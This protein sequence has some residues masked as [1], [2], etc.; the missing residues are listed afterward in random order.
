MAFAL[1][2][3]KSTT[4]G[5]SKTEK[6]ATV[7]L[8]KNQI[9]NKMKNSI[10]KSIL[11]GVFSLFMVVSV[12]AQTKKSDTEAKMPA[13]AIEKAKVPNGVMEQFIKEYPIIQSEAWYGYPTLRNEFEWYD[14]N[15]M[16]YTY[17]NPEY[18]VVEFVKDKTQHKVVYTNEGK[19]VATHHKLK[20][21]AVPV[22][23]TT[24]LKNG[25]YKTWKVTGGEEEINNVTSEEKVYK[26]TVEKNGKKQ[27]LYY[28]A[29]GKLLKGEDIEN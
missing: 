21:Y 15:P 10:L 29:A 17:D 18:Y 20:N 12:S 19:K 6:Q 3:S 27:H 16:Y 4:L 26:I 24:S 7:F 8:K 1:H 23:V 5:N 9:S 13:K 25:T 2:F 22:A 28:D 14:Y 11:I